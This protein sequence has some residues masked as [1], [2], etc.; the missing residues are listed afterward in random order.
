V[1]WI[2][3]I[4]HVQ[5]ANRQDVVYVLLGVGDFRWEFNDLYDLLHLV[6]WH[7]ERD[8]GV[9][10]RLLVQALRNVPYCYETLLRAEDDSVWL[11]EEPEVGDLVFFIHGV[12]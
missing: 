6:L 5:V 3:L 11:R 12:L 4:H 1:R 2:V 8:D 7:L 9:V 10:L